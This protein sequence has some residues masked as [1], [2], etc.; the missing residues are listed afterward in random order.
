LAFE[1]ASRSAAEV[2]EGF[3]LRLNFEQDM[4]NY[5][6]YLGLCSYIG[7]ENEAGEVTP[8]TGLAFKMTS[9]DL[10]EKGTVTFVQEAALQGV[11][12]DL[13][14]KLGG[15][16]I[17]VSVSDGENMFGPS[18]LSAYI[19]RQLG[20]LKLY[21]LYE[22]SGIPKGGYSDQ[23]T[24]FYSLAYSYLFVKYLTRCHEPC[25]LV[26]PAKMLQENLSLFSM[27][28]GNL[29]KLSFF[30]ERIR[31]DE[32]EYFQLGFADPRHTGDYKYL[33]FIDVAGN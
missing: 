3:G 9:L 21:S 31:Q 5:A 14:E 17:F 30:A 25:G 20:V 13:L 22:Q 27:M 23:A 32:F 6:A 18:L 2:L 8:R 7:C 16:T 29:E 24:N 19:S 33:T 4:I 11:F 28:E 1:Q 26:D 12:G 10:P 15:S